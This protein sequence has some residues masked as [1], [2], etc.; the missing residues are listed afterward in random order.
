MPDL[1]RDTGFDNTSTAGPQK[2][3]VGKY[4]LV[5]IAID[6]YDEAHADPQKCFEA[7]NNPVLDASRIVKI[8]TERYTFDIDQDDAA[9][10]KDID[11][12]EGGEP[13]TVKEYGSGDY[14]KVSSTKCFYN[15]N[16][17]R[18]NILD[19]LTL[20][21]TILK[22]NDCLLIYI[23]GHGTEDGFFITYDA[24]KKIINNNTI[25]TSNFLKIS[26]ITTNYFKSSDSC[27]D[28]LIIYDACFSGAAASGFIYTDSSEYASRY[29]LA[30]QSANRKVSDGNPG[31]GS[32]F[33]N[34]L[35][36]ALDENGWGTSE[37]NENE[38]NKTIESRI[39]KFTQKVIYSKLPGI[40]SEG[41]FVFELKEKYKPDTKLLVNCLIEHLDFKIQIGEIEDSYERGKNKLNYIT[42]HGPNINIQ[43]FF[44]K[45][46][47][48]FFF[49][50][51]NNG[52][53]G[54]NYKSGIANH[55]HLAVNS[56]NTSIW[57]AMQNDLTTQTTQTLQEQKN[58]AEWYFSKL[59]EDADE[60]SG[61]RHVIIWI[62][63]QVGS[64]DITSEIKDFIQQWSIYFNNY[65]SNQPADFETKMGRC[66]IIFSDERDGNDMLNDKLKELIEIVNDAN[67][68]PTSKSGII[69]D[70]HIIGWGT[71]AREIGS[72][73]LQQLG[74][75]NNDPFKPQSTQGAY[76]Y[77]VEDFLKKLFELCNYS[78][79]EKANITLSLYDDIHK[80]V[81]IQ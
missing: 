44:C 40:S 19:Y 64:K 36:R 41:K 76:K 1:M 65:L 47:F 81:S 13:I 42:T 49:S 31:E 75:A 61:L 18:T 71:K 37:I 26:D 50:K 14:S 5:A 39:S 54:I 58:I 33:A 45:R 67:I 35:Y 79:K 9:A 52:V 46:I 43:K 21:T 57:E 6:N 29:L 22:P 15:E 17:T 25:S 32:P 63:F 34:T 59:H 60:H 24:P 70:N 38:F 11:T 23:A 3:A 4:Y 56:V 48:H 69:N 53:S 10:A 66:F 68:I 2:P 62:G 55:Y 80:N 12:V 78:E 20:L 73:C 28:L 27:L 7:L 30:S 8:L 16:A 72:T 74:D 77:P 51:T